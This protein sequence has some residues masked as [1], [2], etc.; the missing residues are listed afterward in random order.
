MSALGGK[1]T[2]VLHR[3]IFWIAIHA[4]SYCPAEG[5]SNGHKD[6]DCEPKNS[7]STFAH[8]GSIEASESVR[9]GWQADI[10]RRRGC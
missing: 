5:Q 3:S 1:R 10:T 7:G 2:L 4:V 9:N 8:H 6:Y